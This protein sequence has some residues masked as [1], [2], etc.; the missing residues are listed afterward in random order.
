MRISLDALLVLDSISRNGTFAAAGEELHR[1][2]SAI[3]YTI[4]KLEQDLEVKLFDRSGHRAK[5]TEAGEELLREGRHLL[6]A[7]ND[8]ECRVKRAAT[9]WETELRIALDDIIPTERLFPLLKDFYR[10]GSGTR[11]RLTSEILGGCWDALLSGR[12]DMVIAAPGDAPPEGS[13]AVEPMG[14]VEFVFAIA[15]DHPLAAAAEPLSAQDIQQHR[16][17]TAADTS[18]TLPPRSAGMLDGQDLLS[19]PN[20]RAK[21]AAHIAG[22]GVGYLPLLWAAPHI[23]GG[24][25]VRKDVEGSKPLTNVYLA[26]HPRQAGQALKWFLARLRE[27][28]VQEYVLGES[29]TY[30]GA[31]RPA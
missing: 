28:M 25:L 21:M 6:R 3:T 20:M 23:A 10:E 5:L 24:R 7:A 9:G 19:V 30:P 22:L 2:P 11:V 26:W 27:R 12:A 16:A 15:P 31:D 1:V 13:L 8:I 4:Q 29:G 17:V 18:R 14:R